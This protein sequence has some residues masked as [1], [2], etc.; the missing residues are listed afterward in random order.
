MRRVVCCMI[1][2]LI[3]ISL[4]VPAFAATG[5]FVP[6]I[7]YKD[8]PGVVVASLNLGG[9]TNNDV[10]SC[11]VVTSI[12]EAKDKTTDITQEERDTLLDVYK[13]LSDGTMKLPDLP[14]GY[15]IR[16]LVDV[17]FEYEDC[18]EKDDHGD[19]DQELKKPGVTLT[20][21]FDLGVAGGDDVIVMTYNNG[22]WQPIV[23][24]KNN[25]DGTVTCDFEDICPVAFAV[26]QSTVDKVPKTGDA[27]GQRL[28]LWIGVLAVSGVALAAIVVVAV[29]KKKH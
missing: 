28:G 17:S 9:G 19:K 8:A 23:S 12:P 13:E 1:A 26:K 29:R 24:V 18:R 2:L 22:K 6:S 7:S 27:F 21:T 5:T 4:A 16:D 11:V 15:V 3:C 20:V 14:D 25:G 10:S